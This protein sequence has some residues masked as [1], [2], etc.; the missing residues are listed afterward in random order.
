MPCKPAA[1]SPPLPALF[2]P[3]LG[4]DPASSR[5]PPTVII[6]ECDSDGVSNLSPLMLEAAPRRRYL[7]ATALKQLQKL[8]LQPLLHTSEGI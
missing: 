2:T 7:G 8:L 1:H 3:R 5:Q 6:R 4:E